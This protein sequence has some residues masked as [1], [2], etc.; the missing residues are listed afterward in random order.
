MRDLIL[1]SI[2][3]AP[4]LRQELLADWIY[5]LVL[6]HFQIAAVPVGVENADHVNAF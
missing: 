1:I 3:K 2:K 4:A 6:D 5:G